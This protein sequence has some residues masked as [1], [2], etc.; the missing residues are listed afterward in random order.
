MRL[1]SKRQCLKTATW[2][3]HLDSVASEL[4]SVVKWHVDLIAA[5]AANPRAAQTSILV[6]AWKLVD[7][8]L[9]AD[10]TLL[11]NSCTTRYQAQIAH[12]IP[13]WLFSTRHVGLPRSCR[14]HYT[15][16]ISR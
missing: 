1:T 8:S 2:L 3:Y 7:T 15:A 4:E 16:G 5:L 10:V 12:L 9:L 13:Q 6:S 11:S 14:I